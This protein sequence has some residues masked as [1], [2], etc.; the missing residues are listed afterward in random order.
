VPQGCVLGPILYLIYT[1]E[2]PTLTTSTT[3]NFADD[4]AKLDVQEYPAEV[5]RRLQLHLHEIQSWLRK[6]RM[7][8]NESKSVQI[9]FTFN[10]QTCPVKLNSEQ[11]PQADDVKYLGI[12][13]DRS[14]T[15]RKHL[16]KNKTPRPQT[17]KPVL[18]NW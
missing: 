3:A 8:A 2:L 14:L 12:H 9:T 1:A 17:T 7:K 18:A 6:W 11:L 13:L 10:R 4:T 5:T 16:H 15:R